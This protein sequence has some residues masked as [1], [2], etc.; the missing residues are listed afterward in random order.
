[1]SSNNT[2][3]VVIIGAG[4]HGREVAEILRQPSQQGKAPEVLGFVDDTPALQHQVIDELP[5]LGDWAWF[6]GIDRSEVAVICASGFS[7]TRKMLV[8][9]A[10]ACGFGF[11]NA[12]SNVA[13]ISPHSKIGEGV[14][15]H[16][17]AIACRGTLIE[18]HAILNLGSIVSHDTRIGC[19]GTV[20]PGVSLAGNVSIGE[21]CY[22]GI[23]SSV[24]QGISIGPWTT[25]GAGAAVVRDLPDNVTA[26]GVPARVIKRREK[27]WHEQATGSAGQ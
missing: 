9:R 4:A 24:I 25:I 18:D 12:I 15:I 6:Q 21:G 23:G 17:H 20:N 10:K 11:A 22:L 8:E 16:Q 19:Y 26:V 1:M 14:V 3:R 7:H 2:K 5:I 13:Y 27:G